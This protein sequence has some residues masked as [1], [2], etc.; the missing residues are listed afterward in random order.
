MAMHVPPQ[1]QQPSEPQQQR[2][3]QR[4]EHR[5]QGCAEQRRHQEHQQQ[6][7]QQQQEQQRQACMCP[8]AEQQR[9]FAPLQRLWSR[10]PQPELRVTL[11]RV[12]GDE[13]G[14]W[15]AGGSAQG[16]RGCQCASPHATA[17]LLLHLALHVSLLLH[18]AL[19]ASA[20]FPS[21]KSFLEPCC[22]LA[23]LPFLA[24]RMPWGRQLTQNCC[25]PYLSLHAQ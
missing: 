22:M 2:S 15:W 18:S 1:A 17:L 16:P 5:Q 21:P 11:R 4:R 7:L 6:Q 8:S 19:Q 23:C 24:F 12:G 10:S 3:G 25:L 14:R 13:G 20:C 9:P